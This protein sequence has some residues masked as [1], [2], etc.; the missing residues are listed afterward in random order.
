MPRKIAIGPYDD[1]V[2]ADK[3]N[4]R[5]QVF[6]SDGAFIQSYGGDK[7]PEQFGAPVGV[8]VGAHGHIYV[9]EFGN[10]RV[11]VLVARNSSACVGACSGDKPSPR[12]R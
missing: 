10:D 5:V 2:V 1:I 8:A 11:T 3:I 9:T 12:L 7:D 6:S 4:N